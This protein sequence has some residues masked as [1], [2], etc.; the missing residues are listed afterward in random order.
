MEI[1]IIFGGIEILNVKSIKVE[2]EVILK[3][4]YKKKRC[5]KN[6]RRYII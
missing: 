3:K 6:N 2:N 1:L 5:Y 4:K